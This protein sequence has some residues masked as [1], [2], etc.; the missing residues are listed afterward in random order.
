MR[1]TYVLALVTRRLLRSSNSAVTLPRY[2]KAS[3]A[4]NAGVVTL[5]MASK[6]HCKSGCRGFLRLREP[7]NDFWC[8]RCAH[9]FPEVY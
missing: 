3:T 1:P 6:H 2:H 4:S 7:G 8:P 9:L 5:Y